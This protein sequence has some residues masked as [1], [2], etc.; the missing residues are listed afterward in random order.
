MGRRDRDRRVARRPAFRT[1]RKRI[2]IVSEGKVT[3]PTY[4]RGLRVVF[5]IPPQLLA[6]EFSPKHGDPSHVVSQATLAKRTA[7]NRADQTEDE[8]ERFDEVWV[9]FDRDDHEHAFSAIRT[10]EQVG[11]HVAFS[12]PCI[13]LWLL[14]HFRDS[15]GAQHRDQV[16]K[17]LRE[18]L[19]DYEKSVEFSKLRDGYEQ[20]VKRAQRMVA[21]QEQR[22]E[23]LRNPWTTV[24]LLTESIR[25]TLL[26]CGGATSLDPPGPPTHMAATPGDSQALVTWQAPTNNG[27]SPIV[28]YTAT[29]S[30]SGVLASTTGATECRLHVA[31]QRHRL[32]LHCRRQEQRR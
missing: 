31:H 1:A 10:A 23:R 3:E 29:A 30:P 5:A 22:G 16:K 28:E 18:F 20:A 15:P 13:E 7:D 12:H 27:G 19:P 4:V 26:A 32:H 2:L 8:N 21:D 25:S 14:L 9:M 11:I 6:I 24:H 17:L